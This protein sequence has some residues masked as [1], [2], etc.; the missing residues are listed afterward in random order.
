MLQGVVMNH[1]PIGF[2][3]NVNV[4]A[5]GGVEVVVHQSSGHP[6]ALAVMTLGKRAAAG[7]AA[8]GTPTIRKAEALGVL[9]AQRPTKAPRTDDEHGVARGARDL[10]AFRAMALA[11]AVDSPL[12]FETDRAAQ[13]TAGANGFGVVCL[14]HTD[15]SAA[16]WP[17]LRRTLL[18]R[19]HQRRIHHG[20]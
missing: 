11:N 9:L 19:R 15:F 7:R 3:G 12:N 10:S 20:L 18:L 4:H 17:A 14:C 2:G 6:V 1:V 8:C 13:A 5:D 16:V